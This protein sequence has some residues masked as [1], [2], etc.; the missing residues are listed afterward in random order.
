MSDS[1]TPQPLP[2]LSAIQR[3]VF[4]VLIEKS[5]TTPGGYPLTLNALVTGCNQLT[6]RD[7]VM[8]LTEAEVGR[9][10]HELQIWPGGGLVRQAPADRTA[11]SNRFEHLAESR[12]GWDRRERAIM[13]E[14]LLRGAQTPGELKTNGT[15]M[16]PLDDLQLVMSLLDALARHEP[17]YLR[18]LPRQPGQSTVRYDHLFYPEG[19]SSPPAVAE[20][21]V[22]R[23]AHQTRDTLESRVERLER[24][25][26]ELRDRLAQMERQAQAHME[27]E[28]QAR[29]SSR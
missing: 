19:E 11:R 5:L 16:A 29:G 21:A 1:P 17:P 2:R 23:S 20:P 12:F 18:E 9:A 4:G 22:A 24:E 13:A 8:H 15:R 14:L 27:P 10:L 7:P 25:V 3:R 26:A 28:A 6:C